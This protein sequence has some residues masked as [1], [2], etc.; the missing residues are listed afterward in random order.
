MC[1]NH[2]RNGKQMSYFVYI[3]TEQRDGPLQIGVTNDLARRA[4]EHRPWGRIPCESSRQPGARFTER[5][6]V[7][8]LVYA[9]SHADAE[10]AARRE[11]ALKEWRDDWK[12]ELIESIN[13][14]W[15][16]LTEKL[17]R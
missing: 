10:Q 3:L 1:G 7:R 5:Y 12:V 6:G 13:P 17:V 4:W 11:K 2:V 16:D 15:D 9:E 14:D 8:R